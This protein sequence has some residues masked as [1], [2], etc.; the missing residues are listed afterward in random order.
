[1]PRCPNN[2]NEALYIEVL[3]SFGSGFFINNPLINKFRRIKE[4]F[5]P[6][7]L[8]ISL[9]RMGP[10]YKIIAKVSS[11]APKKGGHVLIG[12]CPAEAGEIRPALF[13]IA[14]WM[15]HLM[16]PGRCFSEVCPKHRIGRGPQ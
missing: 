4:E 3:E 7:I 16:P 12:K 15:E 6:R 10:L 8:S 14:D 5:T 13:V 11:A 1:M 2:S 9:R